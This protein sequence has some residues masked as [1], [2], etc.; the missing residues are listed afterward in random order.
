MTTRRLYLVLCVL[1]V[2]LPYSQFVPWV[3]DHGIDIPL[4][5]RE[6]FA[7]RASAFFALDVVVSALVVFCLVMI[8]GRR[9]GVRHLWLPIAALLLVGVSLGLPL[10]LYQRQAHLDRRGGQRPLAI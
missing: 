9:L 1:G 6:L 10:F 3:A 8:E 2:V 5:A 7:N 4:L